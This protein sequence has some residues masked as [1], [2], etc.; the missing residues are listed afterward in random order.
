MIWSICRSK[1]RKC[2]VV[3]PASLVGNWRN[4]VEKWLGQAQSRTCLFVN[5]P[6]KGPG[7]GGGGGKK[8][9][10]SDNIVHKFIHS[11]P[12][13]HPILV[14]CYE[15]FRLFADAFNT[16]TTLDLLVCDEGHRCGH[17]YNTYISYSYTHIYTHYALLT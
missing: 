13:M 10:G 11:D 16:M 7:G 1:H 17:N 3:C 5:G 4:E 9:G 2:V 8:A 15:S 14:I 12:L 6:G